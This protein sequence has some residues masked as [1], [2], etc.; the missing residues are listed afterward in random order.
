MISS[1][2]R[3]WA[4]SSAGRAPRSQRGGRGFETRAVHQHSSDTS[5]AR[6]KVE[7]NGW[8]VQKN[9][10]QAAADAAARRR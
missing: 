5:P 3:E 6:L 9:L 2:V 10:N 8:R 4:A 7:E 1:F